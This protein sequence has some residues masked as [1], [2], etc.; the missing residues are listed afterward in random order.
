MATTDVPIETTSSPRPCRV[1]KPQVSAWRHPF[2]AAWL[3]GLGALSFDLSWPQPAGV[4]PGSLLTGAALA[5]TAG[6]YAAWSGLGRPRAILWSVL[7][8]LAVFGTDTVLRTGTQLVLLAAQIA[9]WSIASRKASGLA[10]VGATFPSRL[11]QALTLSVEAQNT[12]PY[13]VRSLEIGAVWAV[14]AGVAVPS[15]RFA[16]LKLAGRND[17][18]DTARGKV[19]P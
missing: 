8:N 11:G 7:C 19:S 15:I 12:W 9:T 1:T 5:F 18:K 2:L 14:L 16:L 13:F 4:V 10:A 6:L 17:P 3:A